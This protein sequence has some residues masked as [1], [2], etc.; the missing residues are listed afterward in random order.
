[1]TITLFLIAALRAI[2]EML[3]LCLIAQGFLYLITG[4]SRATNPIYQLFSL[5][6]HRPLRLAGKLFP[7]NARPIA[8]GILVL[9]FLLASW[10]G[11]A[12]LRKIV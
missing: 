1:M 11:L 9:V 4:Q 3:G 8:I 7:D 10:I 2:I 5:I 12:L 6:T